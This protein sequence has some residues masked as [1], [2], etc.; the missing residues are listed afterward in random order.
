MQGMSLKNIFKT[1]Q[2]I[3]TNKQKQIKLVVISTF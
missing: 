1:I 3:K 2:K